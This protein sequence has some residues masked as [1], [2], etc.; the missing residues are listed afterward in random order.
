MENGNAIIAAVTFL[1]VIF[2]AMTEWIPLM[3]AA[4]LGA[5]FLIITNV[6]TLSEAIAY[7]GRSHGTLGLFLGV[8]ILV[9]AFEPTKI[10]EYL[11]TQV[12]IWSKGRGDR[13]LLGIAAITVPICAVLPNATTVMLIA[14]LVP[15]MAA[16]IGVD[17]VPLLILV[18]LLANSSGLLTLVGDPVTFIV[19]DG[20]NLSFM[21]YLERLSASGVLAVL[22]VVALLPILFKRTWRTR[23]PNLES[24]PHPQINH[25][26]T[27]AL[28]GV[29]MFGVLLFF[30]VGDMLPISIEPATVALLGGALALLLAHQSRIETVNHILQ[31][32]DWST[33]IFFMSF[34]VLIGGLEETGLINQLGSLMANT[35]G[36]NM[37]LASIIIVFITGITSSLVPNIPLAVTM[38]PLLKRYCADIGVISPEMM[39]PDYQGQFPTMV[40]P[41]FYAMMLGTT[42]GGNGTLLGASSNIVA[43]GIAEQHGKKISF[44]RFLK[45]GIPVAVA[46]LVVSA[47]YVVIRFFIL[48]V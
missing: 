45:Y 26:K 1:V 3:L 20:I 12:V 47:F 36:N 22:T 38:L 19:G 48:K 28:G 2:L 46:Q 40:L 5:L 39:Q 6:M 30:V 21:E 17:F 10:F 13:L 23:L 15:S 11:A 27:L 37:I 16:E 7:I 33:L 9:R 34:F 31:D 32:V 29:I 44:T 41:L 8:M 14:P 25:P 24:L 43:A 18:V 35:L 4:L 42:L